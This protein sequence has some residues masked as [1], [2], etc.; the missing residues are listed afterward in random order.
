MT[1][2]WLLAAAR[3]RAVQPVWLTAWMLAPRLSSRRQEAT[4]PLYAA[5]CSAVQPAL[6]CASTGAPLSNNIS[7][8]CTVVD[9]QHRKGQL[10]VAS[11]SSSC[12]HTLSSCCAGAAGRAVCAH[13]PHH[14][15]FPHE[16]LSPS[17]LCQSA[18]VLRVHAWLTSS[19][20]LVAAQCVGRSPS[21]SCLV[22]FA[23]LSTSAL[24]T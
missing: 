24:T 23:P 9:T 4:R 5:L 20:P 15:L 22:T 6:L 12:H 13:A 10:L 11:V 21:L 1:P 2:R 7:S 3:C 19:W 17:A 16:A 8:T 18:G 14:P